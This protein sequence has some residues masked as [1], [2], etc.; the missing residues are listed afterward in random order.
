M[1][2]S[3]AVHIICSTH[4][5]HASCIGFP[6]ILGCLFRVWGWTQDLLSDEVLCHRATSPLPFWLF[7]FP[8]LLLDT[9]NLLILVKFSSSICISLLVILLL[10]I[11]PL[12]SW[13]RR[14]A[15][16]YVE[17]VDSTL[18]ICSLLRSGFLDVAWFCFWSGVRICL[19]L[20]HV[21]ALVMR[22]LP[23][24]PHAEPHIGGSH[25]AV[26]VQGYFSGLF[27]TDPRV[28]SDVSIHYYCFVVGFKMIKPEFAS[29]PSWRI[30]LVV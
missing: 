25:L 14:L 1:D 3:P 17:I 24:T 6:L 28:C 5:L 18:C 11:R 19:F 2:L 23:P 4:H 22:L 12:Q 7:T 15:L 29:P 20:F 27:L 8:I 26:Q 10:C 16:G 9:Q 21:P 13:V 30:V